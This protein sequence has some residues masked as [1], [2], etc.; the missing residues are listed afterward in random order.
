MYKL[1]RDNFIKKNE[2]CEYAVIKTPNLFNAYLRT[3]LVEEVNN[4]LNTEQLSTLVDIELLV[5]EL[6]LNARFTGIKTEE[7]F[8]KEVEE[9]VKKEGGYKEKILYYEPDVDLAQGTEEE[10][11]Q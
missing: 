7:D 10:Q 8:L 6:A 11:K 1:V 5:R 4:Y 3:K 9:S 2:Q